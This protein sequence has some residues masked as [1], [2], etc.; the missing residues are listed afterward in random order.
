M[1]AEERAN[2]CSLR[3]QQVESPRTREQESDEIYS[4]R[5]VLEPPPH[6]PDCWGNSTRPPFKYS[7]E[8]GE[9]NETCPL[10]V[11]SGISWL[12]WPARVVSQCPRLEFAAGPE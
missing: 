6:C 12:D 4:A 2:E 11:V 1:T 8:T 7:Q 9:L 10:T 3:R 5:T